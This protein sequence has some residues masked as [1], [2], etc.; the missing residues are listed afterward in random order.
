MSNLHNDSILESLFEKHWDRIKSFAPE[1]STRDV[2]VMAERAAKAEF[3]QMGG[4]HG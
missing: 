1:L 2:D 4:S 3:E